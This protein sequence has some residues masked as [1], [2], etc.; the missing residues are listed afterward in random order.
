MLNQ[1]NCNW[2]LNVFNIS[3]FFLLNFR[4]SMSEVQKRDQAAAQKEGKV[5][6]FI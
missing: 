2:D 6:Q 4:S 5:L 3:F 1:L